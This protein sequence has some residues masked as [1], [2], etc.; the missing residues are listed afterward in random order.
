MLPTI[1]DLGGLVTEPNPPQTVHDMAIFL[2]VAERVYQSG[3]MS[4]VNANAMTDDTPPT[5]IRVTPQN[6][7][8]IPIYAG[9]CDVVYSSCMV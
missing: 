2:D 7:L 1:V 9:D 3:S 6:L 5:A 8:G 4:V